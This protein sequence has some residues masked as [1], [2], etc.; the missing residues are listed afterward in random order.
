M[1]SSINFSQSRVRSGALLARR[2]LRRAAAPPAGRRAR[3]HPQHQ[4]RG[5]AV[6]A[7]GDRR[8][9][10][11]GRGVCGDRRRD[12]SASSPSPARAPPARRPPRSIKFTVDLTANA[13]GGQDRSR[14]RPRSEIRQI[15]D[16]LTAPPAEQPDPHRRGRRRQDGR[17]RG[18]RAAHR[19]RATC[20]SRS[21]TSSLRSLDMGLLQ[22]GAG[23]KGEFENRLKQVIEEVRGSADADHPVHRRSAHDDRRGRAPRARTTRRTCSSPRSRA[24]SCARSR[25]RPGPSTRSTSRR[26]RR[27]SRRFQ[28]IKVEE[29]GDRRRD[30]A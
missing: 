11:G 14:S 25:P 3:R 5:A 26:T 28:P 10:V 13:Q 12:R 30:P 9:L 15:I 29:P 22:A 8:R 17:R 24:A 16:I 4:R 18:L 2:A 7:P 20:P 27:S 6:E 21:R 19:R 23:V 1:Q